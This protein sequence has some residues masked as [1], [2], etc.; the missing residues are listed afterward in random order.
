[1]GDQ[2][3]AGLLRKIGPMGSPPRYE[4]RV[5]DTHHRLVCRTC[6]TVIDVDRAT[7]RCLEPAYAAGFAVDQ[8]DVTFWGVCPDCQ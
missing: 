2:D 6:G 4:T 5:G 8:V 1:M 3:K 7:G